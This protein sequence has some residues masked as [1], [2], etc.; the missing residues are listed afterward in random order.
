MA[1]VLT[2]TQRLNYDRPKSQTKAAFSLSGSSGSCFTWYLSVREPI[3]CD[4]FAQMD[5]DNYIV[6]M[7]YI[8]SRM[9]PS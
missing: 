6:C 9:F 5:V 3:K 4:Y 7:F 2:R 8:P 1:D